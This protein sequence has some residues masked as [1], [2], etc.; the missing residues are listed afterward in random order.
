MEKSAV[1]CEII[2][3]CVC[4][5]NMNFFFVLYFYLCGEFSYRCRVVLQPKIKLFQIEN[6]MR[7]VCVLKVRKTKD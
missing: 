1:A 3:T 4:Y 7:H 2:C 5:H 6:G